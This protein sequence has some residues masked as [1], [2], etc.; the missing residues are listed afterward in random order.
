MKSID[1]SIAKSILEWIGQ[2]EKVDEFVANKFRDSPVDE[3]SVETIEIAFEVASSNTLKINRFNTLIIEKSRQFLNSALTTGVKPNQFNNFIKAISQ[4][5]REQTV[6]I[7]Q[8]YIW[9]L[10]L[11]LIK[12]QVVRKSSVVMGELELPVK[13]LCE[14][15]VCVLPKDNIDYTGLR[16]FVEE[17]RSSED[18]IGVVKELVKLLEQSMRKLD[19]FDGNHLWM[20]NFLLQI[21]AHTCLPSFKPVFDSLLFENENGNRKNFT[22]KFGY[23]E[24]SILI[25]CQIN[26]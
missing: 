3:F 6:P 16:E 9:L 21:M 24:N 14:C 15:L 4:L 25:T 12:I 2:S 11:N 17:N 7:Q 26:S 13:E 18:T 8:A 5:V 10:L 19:N 20:R 1:S 22:N 23:S